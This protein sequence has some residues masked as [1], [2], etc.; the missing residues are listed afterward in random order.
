MFKKLPLVT[1]LVLAIGFVLLVGLGLGTVVISAK[2]GADTD[3]LSFEVGEE[4]G[5]FHAATVER[6][7][8]EAMNISRHVSTTLLALKRQGIVDRDKV[9]AWLKSLLI[10]DPKLLGVWVGME[11]NALDGRDKDFVN[12]PTGDST[13]RFIPYWNRVGDKINYQPLSHYESSGPDGFYYT[14]A[15]RTKREVIVEPYSYLVAGK[16]VLMVSLVVPIMEDGKV[17]GVAG[18]DIANDEIWNE[19]KSAKPFG[20]GSV[21]LISNGGAWAAYSNPDHLGKPILETNARLK[22]AMPAIREGRTFAHFS[23]SASLKTEVKQLFKPVVIDGTGTPWS[24]LVNL[25]INQVEVPKQELRTFIA[26]GAV[27]LTLGLLLALWLTSRMV[28][29]QPLRRIVATIQALT[30]GR[31][32]VE[33]ADRDR[34]DEIG[35]INQALQLFK[36]NAGRVAEMEEQRRLDE[37]RAAEQRR[38][39]LARLADRFEGSVGDVVANVARQAEAIRTDSEGLSAIAEQTNAQAA[40]VASAADVASGNVQTVAAAAEELSHSIEEINQRIAASSRMA[41]DAV[42]EVEKTNGTV[43]G[44]AEAAQKIGEVVNLIQSIAGQT[45]LLALNATIEAARA[46][47]A[48]KGF[49]VV[50]QEVKNLASQTAKATEEIAAQIAEIQA[51]SGNAVGAIQAIGRTILGISETVTAVAAAAEEQGAATR[52]IS[53][54]VQQAAAG[55]RE[56][57]TNIDG[58]TRAAGETGSMASQARAAADTLSH[59]SA[60]LRSEVQRFV[61]TIREG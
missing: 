50:A 48:G 49:A 37:Q 30:A 2:S 59:Q 29:G 18:V 11:P 32:D 42:G 47:E 21:F 22:D 6:R 40:A 24:I 35:A 51:V 7:L 43:A 36:E 55:T 27:L 26:V 5:K 13:G 46:G 41:N 56:V 19:L 16:N 25:P 58:V 10:A 1:K 20:T 45:N 38:Q 31:R 23:V 17:I 14:E 39:E 8:N 44:L 52:E 60:Q 33:V 34:A 53:R 3:A 57:S 28:V 15:K 61:A 4:L 9:S 54:N 12:A